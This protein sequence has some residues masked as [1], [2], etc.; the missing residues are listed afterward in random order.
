MIS[1]KTFRAEY[2]SLREYNIRTIE[3]RDSIIGT[4]LAFAGAL[5][6]G[7]IAYPTIPSLALIFPII[8]VFLTIEWVNAYNINVLISQ[9]IGYCLKP[10]MQGLGWEIY[11]KN[12]RDNNKI[13]QFRIFALPSGLF[14]I[15]QL[16]AIFIGTT[17]HPIMRSQENILQN[18]AA[19]LP[20]S[21]TIHNEHDIWS[22]LLVILLYIDIIC[23]IFS[24][25]YLTK[26]IRPSQRS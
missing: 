15:S 22:Y 25:W 9:Y 12:W 19:T 2:T 18:L 1:K 5:F 11:L 23:V 4:T 13:W 26:A 21:Y 8:A 7:A 17:V 20:I 3:R 14:I 10:K 16:L 6:G 24:A